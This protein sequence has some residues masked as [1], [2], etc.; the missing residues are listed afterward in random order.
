MAPKRTMTRKNSSKYEE[1]IMIRTVAGER[2]IAFV[3]ESPESL[4]FKT[5]KTGKKTK[6]YLC[7]GYLAELRGSIEGPKTPQ[8]SFEVTNTKA[9]MTTNESLTSVSYHKMSASGRLE[10]LSSDDCMA[11]FALGYLNQIGQLQHTDGRTVYTTAVKLAFREHE[12]GEKQSAV[13]DEQPSF[14]SSS[15]DIGN[16]VNKDDSNGV[17]VQAPCLRRRA[18]ISRCDSRH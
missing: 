9:Y 16:A 12:N 1:E 13:Q 18:D 15:N 7:V 17:K 11:V 10:Q 3:L 4:T 6:E 2:K 8:S 14:N 5:Y